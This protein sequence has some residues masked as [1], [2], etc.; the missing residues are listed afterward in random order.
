MEQKFLQSQEFSYQLGGTIRDYHLDPLEDFIA[1]NPKG[2][3]E[4]F[5]GALALMLRSVG[6]ASRV[7]IGFKTEAWDYN[8]SCVIRQSDAHAWVEVYIPPETM[9]HQTVGHYASRWKHGGWLRLDP[10]PASR[11]SSMV[12]TLTMRWTDWSLAVQTFWNEYVLNMN[13]EKQ[14]SGIYEPL[15]QA[16]HFIVHQVFDFAFWQEFASNV[17]QYYRSFFSD[18]PRRERRLGDGLYLIPPF[19]ILGL[20]G[21]ACW[22][23]TSMLLSTRRRVAEELRRNMTIEFYLR[24][25]RMLATIGLIR[26]ASLTPLEFARHSS[27]GTLML[28]VVEAFY[29]VRFGDVL[30]TEEESQSVSESLE[31]LEY[32][33]DS[34]EKH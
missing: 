5:A 11:D 25:E 2:H 20:L 26:S 22:R 32:S 10:T 1:R 3:C 9:P 4:Y 27:F 19:V 33:I 18:G 13:S 31:Q 23:L 12:A 24:M 6:I 21:L 15:S 16:G 29:R 8:A 30:L 34:L 14:R 7:I 28:P 17:V